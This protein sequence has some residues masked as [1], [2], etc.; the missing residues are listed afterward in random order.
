MFSDAC[1]SRGNNNARGEEYCEA[2]GG[3]YGE[4]RIKDM[5]C[6]LPADAWTDADSNVFKPISRKPAGGWRIIDYRTD[7]FSG[8]LITTSDPGASNI[9][10]PLGCKGWHAVYVGIAPF[11][12]VIECKLTGKDK[13]RGPFFNF[14]SGWRE[15]PIFFADLTGNDLEI[16]YPKQLHKIHPKI[17]SGGNII[18]AAV[19][20]V[21]TLPMPG[22]HVKIVK[23]AAGDVKMVYFNDGFGV[24][25]NRDYPGIEGLGRELAM[26]AGSDWNIC[27]FS[28][29]GADLVNYPSRVGTRLNR[30]WNF[31]RIVDKNIQHSMENMSIN[32]EDALKFAIDFA[33]SNGHLFWEYIRP[34]AWT[35]G[36]P[37]DHTFRSEFF[38]NNPQF[39]IVERDGRPRAN[40]LSIAFKAVRK[41]LEEIIH[42]GFERGSDGIMI[43]LARG[44]PLLRYE[45]PVRQRFYDKY[46]M[47]A[48]DVA[49]TDPRLLGVWKEFITTWFREIREL[50]DK[51]GTSP[52][53]GRRNVGIICGPYPQWNLK[54]GVD[55][56]E[57]ARE[58]LI[59]VVIPFWKKS[60]YHETDISA[61]ACILEGTGVEILPSLGGYDD[62]NLPL[63]AMRERANRYYQSGAA[64]LSRWD[65][66][67]YLADAGLDKPEVVKLW[68]E[69]YQG[70][71]E[72]KI[73][74]ISGIPQSPDMWNGF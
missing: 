16:R 66:D 62:H 51:A 19:F 64:G 6:A 29:G 20:S 12:G 53:L 52:M 8:R 41:Q 47:D 14:H 73:E 34:Q 9:T 46:K 57:L 21:R 33:H 55:V 67:G 56:A 44:F 2:C 48:C 69:H 43:C 5:T 39:R 15:E 22:E 18:Q 1:I 7:E 28:H 72:F 38:Q 40:L 45:E 30:G 65:T 10:I 58:G 23:E 68:C 71:L 4:K 50:A 3:I 32:G 42:E 59:D 61:Y 13:W 26:F 17:L 36:W 11:S 35:F 24:F 25:G 60:A 49:D 31:S 37:L 70:K 63:S 74:E 54:Y 27:C